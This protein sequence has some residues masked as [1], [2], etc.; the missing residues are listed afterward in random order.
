MVGA[1]QAAE[2]SVAVAANF[3]VPMQ[4]IAAAFERDT[5]H[6]ATLVFGST[7]KFYTQIKSGAPF[8]VLLAADNQT[9]ALLEREGLGVAGSRFTY[10]TGRLLLWSRQP[11]LVDDQGQVLRT[12]K[13]EH[14]AIADPKLAPYGAAAVEVLKGLGLLAA[15]TPRLVQGTSI[16]QTYQFVATGNAE[17]GFVAVSQVFSGGKLTQGSAW[18]VPAHLHAPIRQDALLLVAGKGNPAAL[19]LLDYL[20]GDKARALIRSFGYEL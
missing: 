16:A 2:V 10:A 9:P 5:G 14:L 8:Q 15:L 12:G 19:A 6:H 3:S 1:V 4:K 7:A 18:R 17:L 11:G 20:R 13:F